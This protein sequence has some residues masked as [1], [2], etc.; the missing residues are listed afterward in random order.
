MSN[1]SVFLLVLA[2]VILGLGTGFVVTRTI[3]R[4]RIAGTAAADLENLRSAELRGQDLIEKAKQDAERIVK[5]GE[6]QAK[7]E[8]FRRREETARESEAA[9]TELREQERRIEKRE[10]A[11]AEKIKDVARKERHIETVQKK[12]ADRKESLEKKSKELDALIEAE[13]RNLHEITGL[14]REAAE[15]MLLDRL[16]RELSDEVAARLQRHTE[17]IKQ[18]ADA[19]ARE[20][21]ST[22]I[23]RC[24]ADHTADTTVSTVDI[25]SDDMKGR[26]I[27]RE[28]R[29]IRTFE[30]C[31]GVDVIVDDTP[32][33]VIV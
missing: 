2:A 7:D 6:L 29:N 18:Q 5:D 28:G 4:G 26:I 3:A 22:T 19:K 17:Q 27:G 8:A 33:V 15:R 10:D 12:L 16:E 23:Q 9:R 31:T 32:G 21:L 14:S 11:V 20:I 13:N 30:K 24:A 1:E 25:P